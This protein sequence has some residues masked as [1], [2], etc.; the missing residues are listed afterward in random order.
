MPP[1]IIK[2]KKKAWTEIHQDKYIWLFNYMKNNYDNIEKDTFIELNKR[3]LMGIIEQNE[4]WGDGSRE[5][6]VFMIA[7][8]LYNKNN[9]DRYVKIYS[10]RGYDY[11]KSN[12][13]K[14]SNNELDEKE[15][16]NYRPYEYFKNILDNHEKP[17]NI[18]AHY[19]YLLLPMLILQPPLRTIFLFFCVS[20]RNFRYE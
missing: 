6:L 13:K 12:S 15:K 5:L 16:I 19:K 17:T 9:S 8:Y 10:Q 2:Q 7:R 1:K 11:M 14:E 18:N 4:K 20:V 3:K